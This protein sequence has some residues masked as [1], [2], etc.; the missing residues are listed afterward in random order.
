LKLPGLQ[1]D[2]CT[3]LA[4]IRAR[5]VGLRKSIGAS[6]RQLILQFI[7]ESIFLIVI[8]FFIALQIVLLALPLFNRLMGLS[9]ELNLIVD[10]FF[11][12]VLLSIAF[13]TALVIMVPVA[14]YAVDLWLTNFAYQVHVSPVIFL[15]S[16][17]VVSIL[18]F[19]TVGYHSYKASLTNPAKVLREA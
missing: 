11:I 7:G 19:L 14:W 3:A 6:R 5:D 4:L 10:P 2:L 8:A 15:I 17:L 1:I 9:L 16:G 18:A 13:V 12:L